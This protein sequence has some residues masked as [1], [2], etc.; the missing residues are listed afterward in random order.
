MKSHHVRCIWWAETEWTTSR[1]PLSVTCERKGKT[2]N[3]SDRLVVFPTEMRAGYL[4]TIIQ[5]Y[6]RLSHLAPTGGIYYEVLF[7]LFL[8]FFSQRLGR[9]GLG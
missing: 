5:N 2:R 4:Q 8:F 9:E 1:Y 7:F 6:Y 3:I